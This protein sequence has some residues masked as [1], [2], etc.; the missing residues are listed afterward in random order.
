[1]LYKAIAKVRTKYLRSISWLSNLN[2]PL[3][4]PFRSPPWYKAMFLPPAEK[5]R[6]ILNPL[7][8]G[9]NVPRVLVFSLA[10]LVKKMRPLGK[11]PLP[12]AGFKTPLFCCRH[13]IAII[14]RRGRNVVLYPV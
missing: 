5:R 3:Y 6:R 8:G 1:M 2:S 12:A 4:T 14:P 7:A 11:L 9:G 13:E 10:T